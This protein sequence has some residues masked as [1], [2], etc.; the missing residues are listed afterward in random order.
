MPLGALNERERK[1]HENEMKCT[2]QERKCKSVY[3]QCGEH[4]EGGSDIKKSR[5][6]IRSWRITVQD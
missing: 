4:D 3:V 1:A 2:N 6:T 5:V